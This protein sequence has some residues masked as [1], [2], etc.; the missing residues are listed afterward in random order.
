MARS[1]VAVPAELARRNNRVVRP[2]DAAGIY[3][4]PRP[5]LARLVRNGAVRKLTHGYYALVP[6][7]HLGSP[8]WRPDLHSLALGIAQCDYGESGAAL[9][10]VGAARVLGAVPRA[11]AVTVVAVPKQRPPLETDYGRILFVRRT[12]DT[13]DLERADTEL[14]QGWITT[15]EQTLLDLAA[16]PTL[17]GLPPDAVT[18][19][20]RALWPRTDA[21]L[22]EELA[23]TQRKAAALHRARHLVDVQGD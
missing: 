5:E 10:G 12:L 14:T 19:A 16:R 11:I 18:E 8:T 15:P 2:Q 23:R 9:M 6:G 17:G 13:L 20:L 21:E 3:V 4:Q 7:R 1:A 22:L